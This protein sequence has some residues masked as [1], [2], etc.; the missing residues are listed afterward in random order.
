MAMMMVVL[1]FSNHAAVEYM[2]APS[3]RPRPHTHL[4]GRAAV[5][6]GTDLP[7]DNSITTDVSQVLFWDALYLCVGIGSATWLRLPHQSVVVGGYR[8]CPA[9]TA[10]AARCNHW[11][12][13]MS[14]L[15]HAL[16]VAL[17]MRFYHFEE[18][19]TSRSCSS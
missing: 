6:A 9:A 18:D 13:R 17:A 3:P 19:I 2:V 16:G 4:A 12:S 14:N 1:L 5:H 7:G 8:A 10:T 15:A 11:Y